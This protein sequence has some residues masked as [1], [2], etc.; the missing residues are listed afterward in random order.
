M[1]VFLLSKK[2][3]YLSETSL[4]PPKN[5]SILSSETHTL[6]GQLGGKIQSFI[7]EF[8]ILKSDWKNFENDENKKERITQI[9][10]TLND[11]NNLT[12]NIK[13]LLIKI[14][15]LDNKNGNSITSIEKLIEARDK[16]IEQSKEKSRRIDSLITSLQILDRNIQTY[17]SLKENS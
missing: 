5:I 8:I 14:E 16:L 17:F 7:E 10:N 2:S 11:I 6:T 12:T 3:K 4:I 13:E 1:K 15:E 9:R